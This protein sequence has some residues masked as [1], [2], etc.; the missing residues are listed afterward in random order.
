MLFVGELGFM[1]RSDSWN[2]ITSF[3]SMDFGMSSSDSTIYIHERTTAQL[4]AQ[5]FPF[6]VAWS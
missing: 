6:H 1:V 4:S 5:Y 3:N 2:I